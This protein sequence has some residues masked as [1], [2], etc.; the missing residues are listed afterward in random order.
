MV[1]RVDGYGGDEVILVDI[2]VVQDG[3]VG[4]YVCIVKLWGGWFLRF[5]CNN[6]LV[7]IDV[8]DV[9]QDV[10]FIVWQKLFGF[11]DWFRFRVWMYIIVCNW[12]WEVIWIVGRCVIDLVFLEEVVVKIDFRQDLVRVYVRDVVMMVL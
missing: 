3:D 8:E 12:C 5:C 11:D 7:M 9:V 4:V 10:L 1:S 6:F 2:C